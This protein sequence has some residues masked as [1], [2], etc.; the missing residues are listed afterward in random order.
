[1]SFL[2]ECWCWGG[3]SGSG[4]SLPSK[5]LSS[6][7]H[8]RLFLTPTIFFLCVKAKINKTWRALIFNFKNSHLSEETVIVL[9]DIK[10]T[11]S[12]SMTC[13]TLPEHLPRCP[14]GAAGVDTCL[15]LASERSG[16]PGH[17]GHFKHEHGWTHD[18]PAR[19]LQASAPTPPEPAGGQLCHR[20]R[21]PSKELLPRRAKPRGRGSLGTG[22]PAQGAAPSRGSCSPIS[23]A[24]KGCKSCPLGLDTRRHAISNREAGRLRQLRLGCC[25]RPLSTLLNAVCVH[26]TGKPV[27][28][29]NA[30]RGQRP[31]RLRWQLR[32]FLWGL[33]PLCS[34]P[35]S[36]VPVFPSLP[37]AARPSQFPLCP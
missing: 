36:F 15:A 29:P 25:L 32:P 13:C 19:V 7:C 1:M 16:R 6:V 3:L 11:L 18:G 31:V 10:L 2:P 26:A 21:A 9:N 5:Q 27:R 28:H 35:V 33:I 12:R 24:M 14:P 30:P 23:S 34:C 20:P 37:S 17:R 8:S 22:G 4:L